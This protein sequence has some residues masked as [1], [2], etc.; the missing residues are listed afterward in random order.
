MERT[1][2]SAAV[3]GSVLLSAAIM[4]N[5]DAGKTQPKFF[6]PTINRINEIV[7]EKCGPIQ[8]SLVTATLWGIRDKDPKLME[9]TAEKVAE[10]SN[11]AL[12]GSDQECAIGN[13]AFRT[14]EKIQDQE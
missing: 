9:I 13:P 2:K 14:Y 7:T 11:T 12:K 5:P 3:V 10:L 6:D 4:V 8:A 1:K